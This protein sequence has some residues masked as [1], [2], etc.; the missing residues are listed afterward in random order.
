MEN[1]LRASHQGKEEDRVQQLERI[2][3]MK[4]ELTTTN[5][6][7]GDERPSY[8]SVNHESMAR[9]EQSRRQQQQQQSQQQSTQ[10]QSAQ[11][12]PRGTPSELKETIKKS[13]IYFGNEKPVYETVA[14]EAMRYRGTANNY[15]QL[16]EEVTHMTA[17]LRKHNFTFGDDTPLYETDYHRG[18][19]SL[20]PQAYG[21]AKAKKESMK[22]VIEDSRACHFSLGNDRPD[23][24]SNTHAAL[25]TIEKHSANDVSKQ[26]ENAKQMKA[27]LQKTSFVIGD[28]EEYY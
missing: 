3:A 28:D 11:R 25:K 20:P 24:L 23:Y 18:Y 15:N 22:A 21:Q 17:N 16:K 5:F 6:R 4:T 12:S 7:L 19:G 1:M 27:A 26:I 8:L 2:K 13:S 10:S 9:V 14:Q